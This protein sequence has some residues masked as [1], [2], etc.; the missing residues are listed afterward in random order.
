MTSIATSETFELA[1]NG[2]FLVNKNGDQEFGLPEGRA[3]PGPIGVQ[4]CEFCPST[5]PWSSPDDVCDCSAI[6]R[7]VSGPHD[8]FDRDFE[9]VLRIAETAVIEHWA[10]NWCDV[11]INES[12]VGGAADDEYQVRIDF[13]GKLSLNIHEP[14][15]DLDAT[16][17]IRSIGGEGRVRVGVLLDE[18]KNEEEEERRPPQ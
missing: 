12:H 16:V 2:P 18:D 13:E 10:P 8:V 17:T 3:P 7:T 14:F 1:D 5:D 11:T 15:D 6:D 9:A 4:T